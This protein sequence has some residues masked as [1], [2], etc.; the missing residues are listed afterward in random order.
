MFEN[1]NY[2]IIPATEI[3]NI[4]FSEV[5][6]TSAETCRYSVDETQT[7]VKYDGDMPASVQAINDRTP[8]YSHTEILA[9]LASE[10]WSA[11]QE[12]V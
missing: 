9:I 2:V 4:N 6:E 3:T 10:A 12:E 5:L 1:R 8:E 11:P 7:F